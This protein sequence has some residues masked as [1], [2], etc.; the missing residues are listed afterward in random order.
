MSDVVRQSEA[1]RRSRDRGRV[2]RAWRWFSGRTIR[3][4]ER[5]RDLGWALIA[6]RTVMAAGLVAVS[7]VD[8]G[9]VLSPWLLIGGGVWLVIM[10]RIIALKGFDAVSRR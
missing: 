6:R 4:A 3:A 10:A 2:A 5:Y 9:F 7:R 1:D 8:P